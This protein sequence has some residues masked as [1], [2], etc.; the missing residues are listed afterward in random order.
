MQPISF[1]GHLPDDILQWRGTAAELADKCN[2]LLGNVGL[3]QEAGCANERL[4]RHYVQVGILRPPA[5]EGR[6][7]IF[8]HTHVVEFLIARRLLLDG[9]SLSGISQVLRAGGPDSIAT[10]INQLGACSTPADSPVSPRARTPTAAEQALSRLRRRTSR[11]SGPEGQ[12]PSASALAAMK[13]S[14]P[15]M[16]ATPR[17]MATEAVP[18]A[19]RQAAAISVRRMDLH[20]ALTGL[21]NTAGTPV[22]RRIIR[23]ELTPWCQVDVDVEALRGLPPDSIE[24]LGRAFAQALHEER[25]SR[26]GKP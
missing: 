4:I 1:F 12:T 22:R 10:W 20:T 8:N 7:A 14:L 5:R 16:K 3:G 24:S 11:P 25:I 17:A 6:E 15:P 2:A 9:L 19:L 23:I 13:E 21:G 26:G 18:E